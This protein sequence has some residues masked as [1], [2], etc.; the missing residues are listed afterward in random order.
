MK[1][2]YLLSL[3]VLLALLVSGCFLF[4]LARSGSLSVYLTDAVANI[5]DLERLDVQ[6]DAVILKSDDGILVVTDESTVVNILDLVGEEITLATVDGTGVYDQLQFD[7]SQAT[8]TVLGKEYPVEVSSNSF[9]YNFK[10]PLEFSEDTTL[11]L[12]FDLSK[13]LK[14]QGR[15]DPENVVGKLHMTPILSARHGKLYDVEG[16][17]TPHATQL[18]VALFPEEDSEILTTFTHHENAKWDEGEFRFPKVESGEYILKVFDDYYTDDATDFDITTL[19][20]IATQS[21]TVPTD[22]ITI[23]LE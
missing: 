23:E 13:S 14:V 1:R 16:K 18:L 6:I 9:K 11:V 10:E 15:W 22:Y 20:P 21:V 19:T 12:D 2:M 8:A 17:V 5:D 4:P 7:V 3:V